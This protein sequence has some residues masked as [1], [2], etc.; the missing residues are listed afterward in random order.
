MGIVDP[1]LVYKGGSVH[2]PF[3]DG[4]TSEVAA[5]EFI[6]PQLSGISNSSGISIVVVVSVE[7]LDDAPGEASKGVKRTGADVLSASSGISPTILSAEFLVN[8]V[9]DERREAEDGGGGNGF[10]TD[11]CIMCWSTSEVVV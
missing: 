1:R 7:K 6:P 11:E 4:V 9:D 10:G 5:S 8:E 3:A 2:D